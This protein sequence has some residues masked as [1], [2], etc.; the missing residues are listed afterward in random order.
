MTQRRAIGVLGGSFNPPHVG[1]LAIASDV[2]SELSLER[3]LFVPASS[4][5]HKQIA[6]DVPAAVRFELTRLAVA[7]DERFEVSDVEIAGGLRYTVD[8]LAELRRRLG[9]VELTFI[10]GSD[11]LLQFA[12]WH[13]PERI[14]ALARLAV[15]PRPGDDGAAVAAAA[16]RWPAG[17]VV[18]VPSVAIDVS[19]SMIRER[20]RAGRSIRYLVPAAVEEA[21]V[22]RG[23]YA[24][25]ADPRA[26]ALM[27][28]RRLA[29]RMLQEQ[30]L[31][32]A[33]EAHCR[34]VAATAEELARRWGAPPDE[35]AAAG[36][37]HD[38]AANCP[39]RNC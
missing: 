18:V 27:D 1:H 19:S 4:P 23:L 31:S 36:L 9:P 15:A 3:V 39:G 37:L 14:L 11:T 35:A 34:A 28:Q 38:W 24:S 10:V 32:P 2:C 26:Q 12:G 30:G 16:A 33:L 25:P 21:I 20:V 17:R 7:A 13:Q 5:P 6:D 29:E 22:G 8:T